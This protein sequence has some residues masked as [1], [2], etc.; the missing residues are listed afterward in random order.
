MLIQ[1]SGE[2]GKIATIII[3][4]F[5]LSGDAEAEGITAEEFYGAISMMNSDLL[6][7][8]KLSVIAQ[9]AEMLR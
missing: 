6:H 4:G 3:R 5:L 7:S 8:R 9:K 1:L 2:N